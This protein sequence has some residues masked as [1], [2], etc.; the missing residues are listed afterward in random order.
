M[1]TLS[2]HGHHDYS[3]RFPTFPQHMIVFSHFHSHLEH[4]PFIHFS[5]IITPLDVT[6]FSFLLFFYFFNT[7]AHHLS[8]LNSPITTLFYTFP[9]HMIVFSHFYSHFEHPSFI[10][11]SYIKTPLDITSFS[12]FFFFTFLILT[13]IICLSSTHQ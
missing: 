5:Y 2:L 1:I 13:L 6:S 11:F 4:P 3:Y 10:H 8:F 12:F 9:Q 7:H